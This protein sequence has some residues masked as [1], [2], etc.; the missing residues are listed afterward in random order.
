MYF[1]RSCVLHVPS[2]A[3]SLILSLS[4]VIDQIKEVKMGGECSTHGRYEK[5]I[6]YFVWKSWGEDITFAS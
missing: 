5:L 3:A 1:Y 6:Q 2:I 4:V